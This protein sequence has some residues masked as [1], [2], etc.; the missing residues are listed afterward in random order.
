M[1]KQEHD[2]QLE[3]AII[4][5]SVLLNVQRFYTAQNELIRKVY[6]LHGLLEIII[7]VSIA[8]LSYV[9]ESTLE[10]Q[11]PATC[12]TLLVLY[13]IT[14]ITTFKSF[15]APAIR[16]NSTLFVIALSEFVVG[17]SLFCISLEMFVP[18]IFQFERFTPQIHMSNYVWFSAYMGATSAFL[19]AMNPSITSKKC[20]CLQMVLMT[21]AH[22]MQLPQHAP[23]IYGA[24][25]LTNNIGVIFIVKKYSS[26]LPK[27]MD[28]VGMRMELENSEKIVLP[29]CSVPWEEVMNAYVPVM[30]NEVEDNV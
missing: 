23:I 4:D 27:L 9:T 12:I 17:L 6:I 1:D 19:L 16:E 20:T 3:V 30:F 14:S 8:G 5:I 25:A 21:A 18:I 15:Y 29:P 7:G 11:T 22:W 13:A 2:A 26:V 28:K 24:I 10:F